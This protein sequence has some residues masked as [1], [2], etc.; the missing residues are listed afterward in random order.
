MTTSRQDK[1]GG[2]A[3]KLVDDYGDFGFGGRWAIAVVTVE[4]DF[5]D[6]DYL[7]DLWPVGSVEA[8]ASEAALPL[9]MARSMQA[10]VFK[11]KKIATLALS[12][13][14]KALKAARSAPAEGAGK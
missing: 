11:N 7:C 13:A 12:A 9:A 14:R 6:G 5:D 8:A 2:V 1:A 10:Y 3:L 4:D